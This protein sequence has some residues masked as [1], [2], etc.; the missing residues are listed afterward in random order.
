M[1]SGLDAAQK[2]RLRDGAG[3][4]SV[5]FGDE[6]AGGAREA[7]VGASD[8]VFGNVPLAWLRGSTALRWVQLDSAGVNA[9]VGLNLGRDRPI[10]VT[11]LHDFYG[12]AVA[13]CALAGMLAFYRRLPRLLVAQS[14]SE[15]IKPKVE[16]EI[17]QLHGAT[18]IILGAGA[19]GRCLAR[20]LAPFEGRVRMFAR[21]SDVAE[22]HTLA[23]LDEALTS[24]DVVVNALPEVNETI[25]ILNAERLARMRSS[26]LVVNVGRGS[27]I[28]EP[29]LLAALDG[30]RLGGAV[31]DVTTVEPLPEKHPFWS[32]PR[33]ILTQHTGGRF[34]AEREGKIDRFLVNLARFDRCEPLVGT[35]DLERG[36]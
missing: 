9:Y 34:P 2:K 3:A 36:Y 4:R 33:V 25:G 26:A 20:L 5:T 18:V 13:E 11:N 1:V 21:T 15:W 17:G 28:D 30:G 7:A 19:I 22:L 6:I 23:Q 27:A 32:H 29:A 16:P 35:V 10:V 24:A 31:L 8:I 12:R 14:R